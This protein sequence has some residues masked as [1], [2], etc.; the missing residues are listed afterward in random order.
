LLNGLKI[1]QRLRQGCACPSAWYAPL[2][3]CRNCILMT[4]NLPTDKTS[5]D[6]EPTVVLVRR[7]CKRC[8]SFPHRNKLSRTPRRTSPRHWIVYCLSLVPL[9]VLSQWRSSSIFASVDTQYWFSAFVVSVT[10]APLATATL[11]MFL[12]IC[13]S[14]RPSVCRQNADTKTR[15]SQK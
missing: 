8:I 11:R 12:S 9:R 13:L 14:V 7:E 3:S 10:K 5:R 2:F 4:S 15:F 6:Y 1:E